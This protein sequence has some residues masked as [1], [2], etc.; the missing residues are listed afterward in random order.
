MSK[1]T[2]YTTVGVFNLRMGG[3]GGAP[4]NVPIR[5]TEHLSS[6]IPANDT[7]ENMVGHR[8]ISSPAAGIKPMTS[9]NKGQFTTH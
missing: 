7:K 6:V 4:V 9:S 8:N 2:L 1:R 5:R 3:G